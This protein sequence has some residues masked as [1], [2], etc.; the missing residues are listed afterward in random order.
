MLLGADRGGELAHHVR[1][2]EVP[3]DLAEALRLALGAEHAAGLVQAFQRRVA[4][5]V[6]DH[7]AVEGEL[8]AVRLQ[9]QGA[10]AELVVAQT[11]LT[12]VQRQRQQFQVLPMQLQRRQATARGRVAAHYQLGVHQR[13]VLIQFEGQVGFIDQVFGRLVILEMNDFRLFGTH[14]AGLFEAAR[15][16]GLE[17]QVVRGSS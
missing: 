12:V 6:D 8:G 16:G 13:A 2:V 9:G 4:F 17:L 14:L 11:Q 1:T 15:S 7:A 3:G 5:G 10:F